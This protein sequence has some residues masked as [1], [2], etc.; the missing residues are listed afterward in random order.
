MPDQPNPQPANQQQATPAPQPF[1]PQPAGPVPGAGLGGRR[2]AEGEALAY[3]MPVMDVPDAQKDKKAKLE[4]VEA[5]RIFREGIA[6]VKD[7]IAPA[8]FKAE[9]NF[10]FIGGKYARTMFIFVYPRFLRV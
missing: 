6:T 10:L 8:A 5:E 9:S 1:V 2:L 7:I 4:L 3:P